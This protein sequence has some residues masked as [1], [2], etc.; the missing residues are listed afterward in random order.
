MRFARVVSAYDC[1]NPNI[2][3]LVEK[4]DL[5]LLQI[6][7]R[8]PRCTRQRDDSRS[9]HASGFLEQLRTLQKALFLDPNLRVITNAGGGNTTGCVEALAEHLREHGS[10]EVPITSIRGDNLFDRL[11]ELMAE[12]IELRDLDSGMRLHELTKPLL[13]A[14]V[15]LGGGPIKTALDEGSRIVVTG[16]Y[17]R[18]APLIASAVHA[19]SLTWDQHDTLAQLAYAAVFDET[20]VQYEG[21]SG[22]DLDHGL[23]DAPAASPQSNG[24]PQSKFADVQCTLPESKSSSPTDFEGVR[25]AEP[26]GNWL[27]RVEYAASY[28]VS[29]MLEPVDRDEQKIMSHLRETLRQHDRPTS[30]CQVLLFQSAATADRRIQVLANCQEQKA[31]GLLLAELRNWIARQI[32]CGLVKNANLPLVQEDVA[33]FRCEVPRD[34]IAVSVDTRPANEWR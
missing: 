24:R 10:S 18:A 7:Y 34:A 8:W 14:H 27:L 6:D 2:E 26:S 17:D 20:I 28:T 30:K 23:S 5:D 13:S 21:H 11:E 31:A 33:D 15:E 29:A 1:Y 32:D 25:G 16:C 3:R 19:T 12:G 4:A 9:R 22:I